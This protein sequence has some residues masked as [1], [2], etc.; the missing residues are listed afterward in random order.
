M[1]QLGTISDDALPAS[2]VLNIQTN[3][4]PCL[5]EFHLKYEVHEREF[6][7]LII[8]KTVTDR[9]KP[10]TITTVQ[11]ESQTITTMSLVRCRE[12]LSSLSARSS[13]SSS[14][15]SLNQSGKYKLHTIAS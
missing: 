10:R 15:V 9:I 13:M 1:R 8:I 11:T 6:A 14:T 2:Q 3:N 4:Q 5:G 12:K 7:P